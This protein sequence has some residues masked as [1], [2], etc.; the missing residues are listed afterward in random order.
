MVKELPQARL[1]HL[2]THGFF[3]DKD[4]QHEK[5]G[6]RDQTTALL[7]SRE[8]L[9]GPAGLRITAGAKSRWPTL[10]CCW[11]APTAAESGA[12][13]AHPDG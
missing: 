7:A 11:P 2:A 13:T 3:N 12:P 1:V 8:I 4:F 5:K 10:A 9:A 6:A